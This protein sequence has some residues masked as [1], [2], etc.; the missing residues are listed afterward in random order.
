MS[1][2]ATVATQTPNVVPLNIR[3]LLE[4]LFAISVR[5]GGQLAERENPLLSRGGPSPS[6]MPEWV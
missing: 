3:L 1:S 5:C 2:V 4:F 6:P